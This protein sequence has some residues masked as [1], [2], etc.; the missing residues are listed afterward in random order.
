MQLGTHNFLA[1]SLAAQQLAS[2]S[3][4]VV[5]LPARATASSVDDRRFPGHRTKQPIEVLGQLAPS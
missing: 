1:S 2:F 5:A 4:D 3:G